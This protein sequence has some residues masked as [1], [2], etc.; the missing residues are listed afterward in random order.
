M[1]QELSLEEALDILPQYAK[2]LY[3]QTVRVDSTPLTG[4]RSFS[5]VTLKSSTMRPLTMSARQYELF[6]SGVLTKMLSES[7]TYSVG[8]PGLFEDRCKALIR[9]VFVDE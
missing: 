9:E 8:V 1:I 6:C 2:G 5:S 4:D 3:L 7:S